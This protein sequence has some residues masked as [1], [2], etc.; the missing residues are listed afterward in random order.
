MQHH[1]QQHQQHRVPVLATPLR[2]EAGRYDEATPP[3]HDAAALSCLSAYE[4]N[5]VHCLKKRERT[6]LLRSLRDVA[7]TKRGRGDDTP[8]RIQVLQSALPPHVRQ[9][10][11][12]DL[13]GCASDKYVQWV[14]RALRLPLGVTCPRPRGPGGEEEET[15]AQAVRRARA[16]M[17]ASTAGH[18]AAKT[19]VLKAVCAAASGGT[20]AAGYAL[21]LEGP[22]GIG[23]THFVETGVAAALA[24]PMVKVKL[25]GAAD[26]AF[27]LGNMYTYEGSKEGALAAGL[28]EAGCCDPIFYFDEVDK[29]SETERG[30]EIVSVLIHL[31]DPTSNTAIRDRYLHGI[32][33]D[34]SKCTFVFS[35]NDPSRV[36][37]ILL[38]RLQRVRL[39][40]PTRDERRSIVLT[41]L[42]PRAARRI[43]SS[44]RLDDEGVDCIVERSLA[45]AEG[46]RGAEQD[47]GHVL[48]M[49]Q[50]QRAVEEEEEEEGEIREAGKLADAVFSS[51]SPNIIP[52]SFV[53]RC[54]EERDDAQPKDAPPCNMYA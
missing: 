1:Q 23:K 13:R 3:Q 45:T 17:D 19:E 37:P 12:D 50:L 40:S 25:G 54:L 28:V 31:V 18:A 46:M 34:F 2:A 41:H 22:P 43:H 30:R 35:Y 32:D 48:S 27:L 4:R 20:G 8:L 26:V 21:G 9:Q 11:F 7:G 10:V 5:Y 33:L 39:S 52:A 47:V 49:A 42:L 53:R 38:D 14:K 29:V 24:K 16:A 51:S 36:S 44:A 15:P 6:S